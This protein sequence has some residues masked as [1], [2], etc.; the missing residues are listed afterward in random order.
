MDGGEWLGS[1]NPDGGQLATIS[2]LPLECS[3]LSKQKEYLKEKMQKGTNQRLESGRARARTGDSGISC[4]V[5]I[6]RA[7]RYT[8]QPMPEK[9]VA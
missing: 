7:N 5:K 9:C 8:T 3:R 2:R 6:P 4:M 1:I